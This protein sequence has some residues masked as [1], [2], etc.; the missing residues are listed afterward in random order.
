M[1]WALDLSFVGLQ[2]SFRISKLGW[3]LKAIPLFPAKNL[4][5]ICLKSTETELIFVSE[6]GIVDLKFEQAIRI[7][8]NGK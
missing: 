2:E 8:S 4:L 6:D 1:R 7:S 3:P 5:W